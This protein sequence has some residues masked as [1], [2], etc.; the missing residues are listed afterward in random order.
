MTEWALIILSMGDASSY[1]RR[2]RSVAGYIAMLRNSGSFWNIWTLFNA[3][4]SAGHSISGKATLTNTSGEYIGANWYFVRTNW[5]KSKHKW[6]DKNINRGITRVKLATLTSDTFD[7]GDY[8][9][10]IR[11][12]QMKLQLA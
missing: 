8:N 7:A 4:V 9:S 6:W 11:I 12:I 1:Q 5:R 3:A 2:V 10:Y